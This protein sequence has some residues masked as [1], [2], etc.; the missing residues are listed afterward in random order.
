[1][2]CRYSLANHQ[3]VSLKNASR[4]RGHHGTLGGRVLGFELIAHLL[5]GY[6]LHSLMLIDM[7]NDPAE[8]S[9]VFTNRFYSCLTSHA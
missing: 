6:P 7:F 8:V 4:G 9:T 1:M 2:V 5:K 3:R